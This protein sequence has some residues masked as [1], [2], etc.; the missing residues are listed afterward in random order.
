MALIPD[1]GSVEE[2]AAAGL[3]PAFHD[4]VHTGHLDATEND[5][6][7]GVREDG[8]EPAGE[9]GVSVS[10]HEPRLAAGGVPQ[11]RRRGRAQL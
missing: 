3:Y 11:R 5:A 9:F 7:P 2:F 10:D 6:D 4:R 8:V 1:Q